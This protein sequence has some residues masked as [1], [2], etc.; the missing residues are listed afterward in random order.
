MVNWDELKEGEVGTSLTIGPLERSEFKV[1]ANTGGDT[2]PIHVDEFA[3]LVNKGI[4]AHGLYTHAFL[5]KMLVDWVGTGNVRMYQGRM[6]G[7]T[8][9]GD[10]VTLTAV[11]TKKYEKDGEK[12]VDLDI[13][14]TTRTVYF[15]GKAK[16]SLSDEEVLKNLA[17]TPIKINIEFAAAGEK[18]HEMVFE[19]QGIE[20]RTKDLLANEPLIRNWVRADKDQVIAEIIGKRKGDKFKFGIVRYRDAIVGTATVAI[21]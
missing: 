8:R 13:K 18:K 20:V 15:M 11:V 6:L 10:T 1:Y 16:S 3:G 14:S 4:I 9:P 17:N 5:G 7:M 19:P 21:P 2:N 12:L